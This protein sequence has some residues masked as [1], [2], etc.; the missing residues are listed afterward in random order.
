MSKKSRA[1]MTSSSSSQNVKEQKEESSLTKMLLC[2]IT[3]FVICNLVNGVVVWSFLWYGDWSRW[4]PSDIEV[5]S[6][7][8]LI[9]NSSSNFII[10]CFMGHKFRAELIKMLPNWLNAICSYRL[11]ARRVPRTSALSNQTHSTQ[12]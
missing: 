8:P 6:C 12:L 4:E 9:I 10:Y 5:F 7:I 1:S 3:L 11:T 2:I